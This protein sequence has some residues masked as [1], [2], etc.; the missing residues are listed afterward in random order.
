MTFLGGDARRMEAAYSGSYPPSI[1]N[2]GDDPHIAS[3]A[4]N[5]CVVNVATPI[6]V[7]GTNFATD[8]AIEVNNVA[9]ATTRV[10]A[11]QLTATY[12]PATTGA[13]TI[14]VRNVGAAEESN[15]VPFTV[16][17]TQQQAASEPEPEPEVAPEPEPPPEEPVA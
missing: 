15:S 5:T 4:P 8:A 16:T 6:T 10:S 12:T 14:T 11:T 3:V 13:K 17:A 2:G 1:L 9:I 7:T